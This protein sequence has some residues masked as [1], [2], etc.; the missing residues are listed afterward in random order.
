MFTDATQA[1]GNGIV[2]A[3]GTLEPTCAEMNGVATI[4]TNG[5]GQSP[6]RNATVTHSITGNIIDRHSYGDTA[7][8]IRVCAGT[9][10]SAVVSDSSGTPTLQGSLSCGPFL[11]SGPVNGR[12]SYGAVSQDGR[13]K[14]TITFLPE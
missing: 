10:V 4:V 14:D 8:R 12:E 11:C 9:T 1:S 6:T 2:L 3:V 7:H 5:K 13:D